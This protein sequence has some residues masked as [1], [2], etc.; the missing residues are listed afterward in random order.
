[1]YSTFMRLALF[2]ATTGKAEMF[3]TATDYM[4]MKFSMYFY[5]CLNNTH[6]LKKKYFV[7]NL[8]IF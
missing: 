5:I 7:L 3:L 4:E 8:I 2:S 1:M 6:Y